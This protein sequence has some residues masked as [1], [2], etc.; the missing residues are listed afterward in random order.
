MT[1]SKATAHLG[2]A[3]FEY[4]DESFGYSMQCISQLMSELRNAKDSF[5]AME[6]GALWQE[7]R[8]DRHAIT[9]VILRGEDRPGFGLI[10]GLDDALVIASVLAMAISSSTSVNQPAWRGCEAF[11]ERSDRFPDRGQA[12]ARLIFLSG[13]MLVL[14]DDDFALHGRIEEA[15]SHEEPS[16]IG[17]VWTAPGTSH[18]QAMQSLGAAEAARKL[19]EDMLGA[20]KGGI[21]V[22]LSR[23]DVPA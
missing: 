6:Q 19:V 18:H 22:T 13:A 17:S 23:Q 2:L 20:A 14:P 8:L 1:R 16:V 5:I 10:A 7:G 11:A 9:R 12:E 3:H 21:S 15:R 4:D